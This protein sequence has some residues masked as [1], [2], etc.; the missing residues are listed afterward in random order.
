MHSDKAERI[1]S[2]MESEAKKRNA[3]V[4][5]FEKRKSRDSFRALIFV[6]LSART[7]DDA[8]IKA[9]EALFSF[10]KD[11]KTLAGMKKSEVEKLIKSVG[12]YRQKS[13]NI[14]KTAK[15]ITSEYG[16]KVPAELNELMKLPGVGR[17]SANVL[18]STVFKKNVIAVDT[19]VHR[20]SNRLGFVKTKRPEETEAALMKVFPRK[21]WGRLNRAMVGYGQTV[22]VPM[23]PFCSL[24]KLSKICPKKGV[25]KSR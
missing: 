7:K 22:C 15:I 17:K 5:R 25:R 9:G 12:F 20:I 6:I 16:G 3:P 4:F 24:C 14:I 19:H 23:G 2:I 10:A 1:I 11:A 13:K 8:T 21:Y 18:L